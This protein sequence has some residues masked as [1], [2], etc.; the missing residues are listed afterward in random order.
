M[1]TVPN[2]SS[3]Q[4]FFSTARRPAIVHIGE[5]VRPR[6]ERGFLH[7]PR[8]RPSFSFFPI[9]RSDIQDSLE[10]AATASGCYRPLN[11]PNPLSLVATAVG[12]SNRSHVMQTTAH[13]LVA[14]HGDRHGVRSA[15][16]SRGNTHFSSSAIK[17][18]TQWY[19][20]PS[21]RT[22]EEKVLPHRHESSYVM[23]V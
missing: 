18:I 14:D 4:P 5:L 1:T 13:N 19:R 3:K 7:P 9:Y 2:G 10:G 15:Q 6:Y 22:S 21:L 12:S 8:W 23:L 11:Q 20:A 17:C 16:R